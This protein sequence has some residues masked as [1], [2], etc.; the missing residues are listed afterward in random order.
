MVTATDPTLE[1]VD[2]LGDPSQWVI[3][4]RVPV[5]RPHNGAYRT[6]DG[7]VVRYE[8]TA[9]DLADIAAFMRAQEAAGVPARMTVGHVNPTPDYPED[10]NPEAVGY[11]LGATVGT[12]GPER[13]PCL[14]ADSYVHRSQADRVRGRV[15]RSAEYYPVTKQLTG[16]AVI[17]RD[18][19]LS[20]GTV[21][22]VAMAAGDR[23]PRVWCLMGGERIDMADDPTTAKPDTTK[24]PEAAKP[25]TGSPDGFDEWGLCMEHYLKTAPHPAIQY[26]MKCYDAVMANAAGVPAGGAPGMNHMQK[27][28]TQPAKPDADPEVAKLQRD[29]QQAQY[30]RLEQRLAAIESENAT[31]KRERD[32]ADRLSRIHNLQRMGYQLDTAKELVRLEKPGMDPD[33]WEEMVRAHGVPVGAPMIQLART[34]D[35]AAPELTPEEH[36]AFVAY[37][38]S[39]KIDAMDDAA[40]NAARNEFVRKRRGA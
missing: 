39:Q 12:F 37:A 31:L 40:W 16:V 14:L 9:A 32:K 13:T 2:R 34:A 26:A 25:D 18:P 24:D 27:H 7:R 38:R 30:A 35:S 5:F 28:D 22:L 21:E 11:W 6:K 29:D 23:G 17:T 10:D 19:E 20:L 1:F 33:V 3:R 36:A 4:R 15:Y 8:V